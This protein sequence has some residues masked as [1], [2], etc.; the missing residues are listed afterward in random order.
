MSAWF[1]NTP[2]V[3]LFN[4]ALCLGFWT[5]LAMSLTAGWFDARLLIAVPGAAA[6]YIVDR[7]IALLES[8][9]EL[10]ALKHSRLMNGKD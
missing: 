5:T 3:G 7:L 4:C 6:A 8:I 1:V 9:Q 2:L 10:A